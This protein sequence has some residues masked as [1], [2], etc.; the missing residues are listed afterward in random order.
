MGAIKDIN[1]GRKVVRNSFD[2]AEYTPEDSEAWDAAYENW[3]KI[4]A[5]TQK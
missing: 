2:I 3:K 5:S 4:V 1:E